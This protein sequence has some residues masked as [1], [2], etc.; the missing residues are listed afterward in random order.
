MTAYLLKN[1]SAGMATGIA[2]LFASFVAGMACIGPLAGIALGISSLG[3]M[4]HYSYLTIPASIVSMALL[5]V[6]LYLFFNSKSCCANKRRH[7]MK[8]NL[9]M[10]S[11]LIVIGINTF[12]W[13]IFPN[14]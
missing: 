8:R 1:D 7:M 4:A 6:A 2:S 10:G 14:L 11:A 12:E 13:L 5:A 9:L 3:W